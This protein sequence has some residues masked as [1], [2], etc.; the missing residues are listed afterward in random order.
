MRHQLPGSIARQQQQ[1][2]QCMPGESGVA[3]H[4]ASSIAPHW[5]PTASVWLLECYADARSKGDMVEAQSVLELMMQN[6]RG[7][8]VP[9]AVLEQLQPGAR[10]LRRAAGPKPRH[11]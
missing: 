11:R 6:P 3:H 5:S 8:L 7:A 1:Q 9:A 2:Q 10:S 4:L